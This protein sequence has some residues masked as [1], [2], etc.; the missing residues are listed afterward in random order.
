MPCKKTY[1][2]HVDTWS[3]RKWREI[4]PV[5]IQTKT[6]G[7]FIFDSITSVIMRTHAG[8][9]RNKTYVQHV[10]V[11]DEEVEGEGEGHGQQQPDVAL[12]TDKLVSV[13]RHTVQIKIMF[14]FV[15]T[16]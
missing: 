10:D 6:T 13:S 2:Q 8:M 11:E 4:K 12:H 3:L 16:E 1:V 14:Y 15:P 7:Y 5:K 9:P